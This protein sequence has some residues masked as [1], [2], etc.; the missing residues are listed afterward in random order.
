MA[1]DVAKP[2]LTCPICLE[3]SR[4]AGHLK[5]HALTHFGDA[6][7]RHWKTCTARIAVGTEIPKRSLSTECTYHRLRPNTRLRE[8]LDSAGQTPATSTAAGTAAQ[9]IMRQIHAQAQGIVCDAKDRPT[10]S[11]GPRFGFLESSTK[12]NG[13]NEA[14]SYKARSTTELLLRTR[15]NPF[16]CYLHEFESGLWSYTDTARGYI[17]EALLAERARQT[18]QDDFGLNTCSCLLLAKRFLDVIEEFIFSNP[19]FLESPRLG[20]TNDNLIETRESVLILQA[21]C[22]M[23]LLQKWEGTDDQNLQPRLPLD[24]AFAIFHN[25]LPRMVLQEMTIDLTCPEDVALKLHPPCTVPLLTD[26]VRNL[27][28]ETPDPGVTAPLGHETALNLF[29]IAA[30]EGVSRVEVFAAN[31]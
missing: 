23:C 24:S 16:D 20:S 7:C 6:R 10:S 12:A 14:Y 21:T 26:C 5:R 31:S 17:E 22:F 19:L 1:D 8:P 13:L 29:T 4:R 18:P 15:S 30:G 3:T 11:H 28:A 2:S 9:G 27:S 25:S